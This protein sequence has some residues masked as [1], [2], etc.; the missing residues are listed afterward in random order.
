VYTSVVTYSRRDLALLVPA[1]AAA[2]PASVP[3]ASKAYRFEDVPVRMAGPASQRWILEGET[4]SG[5]RI[6]L[7]HTEMPAGEAGH[8]AHRHP[9]DELLLIQEGTVEVTIAGTTSKLGPGSVAYI[10]SNDEHGLRNVGATKARYFALSLG[11]DK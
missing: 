6:E 2:A 7:H 3:L 5:F 1:L 10:A 11:R 8:A 4:H 9:H